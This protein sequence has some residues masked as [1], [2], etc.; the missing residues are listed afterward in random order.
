MSGT[1]R[2]AGAAYE[3]GGDIYITSVCQSLSSG[4]FELKTQGF[5]EG[6]RQR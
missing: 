2:G 5:Y 3:G 1:A 4:L 6:K